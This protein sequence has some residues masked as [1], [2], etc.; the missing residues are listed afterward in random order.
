MYSCEIRLEMQTHIFYLQFGFKKRGHGNR[1]LGWGAI[2]RN[3][4]HYY[5][6]RHWDWLIKIEP[7]QMH[8]NHLIYSKCTAYV[9]QRRACGIIAAQAT[10]ATRKRPS[11]TYQS[12]NV[13][14]FR[15][16]LHQGATWN[17]NNSTT[18]R[19]WSVFY[20]VHN[21]TRHHPC[22]NVHQ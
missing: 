2:R 7:G 18:H 1:C 11:D 20:H 3:V 9:R 6:L 12:D 13:D 22:L 16:V 19:L 17:Q 21:L 15:F 5:W 10:Q 14:H 4:K 8:M